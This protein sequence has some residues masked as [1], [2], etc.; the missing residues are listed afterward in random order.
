MI[1]KDWVKTLVNTPA[2]KQLEAQ[3]PK[4]SK[5]GDSVFFTTEQFPWAKNLEAN[6]YLIRQELDEVLERVGELPHG[7]TILLKQPQS[8]SL[9]STL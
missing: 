7:V 8:R 2:I 5:V 9:G 1:K 6:W 4:Y 3:V